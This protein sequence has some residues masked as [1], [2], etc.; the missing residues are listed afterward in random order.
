MITRDAI[1]DTTNSPGSITAAGR[2]LP[3]RRSIL[4]RLASFVDAR[5]IPF[6]IISAGMI[7]MLLWAGAFKMTAPGAEAITPL[8][9]HSPLIWWHFKLFGPYLGSDLI[10]ATEVTTAALLI[11]GYLKPK[12]GIL[13][14]LI[15]V[16]MFFT[17]STMLLSTPGATVIVNGIRYMSFLGLFLFKD[18]VSLGASFYLIGHFGQ[19]AIRLSEDR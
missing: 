16:I 17:T 18:I 11:V 4:V 9:T 19:R 1:A 13:G 7:A 3:T 14:G 8:V 15:A 12:A 2:P 10:G 6:L 5:G